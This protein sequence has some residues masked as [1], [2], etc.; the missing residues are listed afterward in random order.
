MYSIQNSAQE[1]FYKRKTLQNRHKRFSSMHFVCQKEDSI[2]HMLFLCPGVDNFRNSIHRWFGEIGYK[3]YIT[4]V[5]RIIM[6]D[7]ENGGIFP[8]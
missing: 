3:G 7:L 2:K 6:G 1:V 5:E 8:V 4:S